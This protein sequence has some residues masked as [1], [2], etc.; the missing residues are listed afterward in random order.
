LKLDCTVP[1]KY[2]DQVKVGQTVN[3]VFEGAEK[4]YEAKI[5]ATESNVTEN[6]RS[7]KVRAQVMGKDER[8]IPGAFAKVKLSFAPDPNAILVPTQAILP[9]A[10]GKKAILYKSGVATSADV[11]TGVRDSARVQILEGINA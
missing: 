8:L 6:T 5:V 2:T 9:Q 10:R 4:S 11:I 1:E 7:L 3:F